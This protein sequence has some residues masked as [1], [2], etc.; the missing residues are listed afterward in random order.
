MEFDV[1]LV[2]VVVRFQSVSEVCKLETALVV[3]PGNERFLDLS[4]TQTDLR[5]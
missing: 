5:C 2:A 3:K 4:V 1:L